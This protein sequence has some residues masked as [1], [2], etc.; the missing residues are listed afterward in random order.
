MNTLAQHGPVSDRL[1]ATRPDSTLLAV[2]DILES[3]N[4]PLVDVDRVIRLIDQQPSNPVATVPEP[5]QHLPIVAIHGRNVIVIGDSEAPSLKPDDVNQALIDA[6]DEHINCW[7]SHR[8]YEDA[9]EEIG[10]IGIRAHM[11]RAGWVFVSGG[12]RG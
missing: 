6:Y 3:H 2:V 9:F 11:V 7:F 12:E 10:S 8:D 1:A 5:R 4:V